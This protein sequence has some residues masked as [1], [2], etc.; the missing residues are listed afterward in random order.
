M[1]SCIPVAQGII[2]ASPASQHPRLPS[3]RSPPCC[4]FGLLQTPGDSRLTPQKELETTVCAL[5]PILQHLDLTAGS[6]ATSTHRWKLRDQ[7]LLPLPGLDFHPAYTYRS[8][9]SSG[10]GWSSGT[11]QH[12]FRLKRLVKIC[13]CSWCI[14]FFNSWAEIWLKTSSPSSFVRYGQQTR[15]AF[16]K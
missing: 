2:I 1:L 11:K 3:A 7:V 16:E 10:R 12:A 5:I 9:S 15:A 4:R 13:K 14:Q 8:A 6:P